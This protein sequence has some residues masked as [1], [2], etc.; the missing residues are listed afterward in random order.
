MVDLVSAWLPAL[1][2]FLV[3]TVLLYAPG[4]IACWLLGLRPTAALGFAPIATTAIIGAGAVVF[5]L[6]GVPFT[7]VSF[8]GCGVVA[9]A[10]ALA[11]HRLTHRSP[12]L[13]LRPVRPTAAIGWRCAG[14]VVNALVVAIVYVRHIPGAEAPSYEYD[15]LWHLSAI[16]WLMST[17]DFSS[18]DVGLL[19]GTSGGHFYPAAWHGLVALTAELTGASIPAAV[20]G[21]VLALVLVVWPLGIAAL[22]REL[23]GRSRLVGFAA[24]ALSFLPA[25]FPIGFVTFGL[26][27]S[28]LFGYALL[29]AAVIVTVRVLRSLGD[30]RPIG[31]PRAA[32]WTLLALVPVAF[33]FAQPNSAFTLGVIVLPFVLATLDR[34]LRRTG[35]VPVRVAGHVVLV[36]VVAVL[37]AVLHDTSFLRRTVEVDT[38]P[39][40][41]TPG[42]AVRDWVLFGTTSGLQRALGALTLIGM[43]A[44]L[45]VRRS[46]WWIGGWV[47]LGV[48]YIVCAAMPGTGPHTLRSYL[49]GFWYTDATRMQ[50]AG[51]VVGIPLM[52]LAIREIAVRVSALVRSAQGVVA[53]AAAVV[54]VAGM[55]VVS[56]GVEGALRVR[57]G[58]VHVITEQSDAQWL[59]PRELAFAREAA[60]I[61]G[62]NE[63]VANNPFDGSAA[64]YPIAD[65]NVL[66]RSLPGN[67]MGQQTADQSLMA[68]H[69]REAATNPA[70]CQA[71]QRLG[72]H[73]VLVLEDGARPV[74]GRVAATFAGFA[75][76]DDTPG[77]E[78]VASDGPLRLYRL[79][80][81]S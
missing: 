68:D 14:L 62:P 23:F 3:F 45:L 61:V 34:L 37:W 73:D 71:A 35:L 7:V 54:M 31:M 46:R 33:V 72:V 24:C 59:S 40:F 43:V 52:A 11:I 5:G 6:L 8:L 57:S 48:A 53:A 27:Y 13:L 51:A 29:P 55:I 42:E 44:A 2:P 69:L 36:G 76:T 17:G 50:A 25:A 16:K 49:V 77:F 30:R 10:V 79:T 22:T 15:T 58:M 66:F 70:V 12:G 21:A 64:A 81:C 41:Q 56:V 39:A 78:V 1:W 28:N 38:W 65:L 26:L 80:A 74:F 67:W 47:L 18:L 32:A 60:A 19:D 63:V 4:G 9:C 75:I 20:N